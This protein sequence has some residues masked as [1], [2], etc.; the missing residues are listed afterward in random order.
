MLQMAPSF[1]GAFARLILIIKLAMKAI[2][3]RKTKKGGVKKSWDF[4]SGINSREG[5]ALLWTT[6]I[7]SVVTLAVVFDSRGSQEQIIISCEDGKAIVFQPS[8]EGTAINVVKAANQSSW[9]SFSDLFSSEAYLDVYQTN[10]VQDERMTALIFPPLYEIAF[11][12]SCQDINCDFRDE[13]VIETDNLTNLSV[14][15]NL[16]TFPQPLPAE[17]ANQSLTFARLDQVGRRQVALFVISE[18]NEERGLA[19][20]IENNSYKPLITNETEAQIKTKYGKG[21]GKMAVGGDDDNFILLYIGYE[22]HAFHY[23]EGNLENI[24]RFFGLRVADNGFYPYI[25]KQGRGNDSVWYVLSLNKEKT[26]LIKLWQNKSPYIVGGYDLSDEISKALASYSVSGII[27]SQKRGEVGFVINEGRDVF[28]DYRL[29]LFKDKG[30][31]NS[32]DRVAISKNIKNNEAL[33]I[34]AWIDNLG[35][36]LA[37]PQPGYE[38]QFPQASLKVY[39]SNEANSFVA[40]NPGQAVEFMSAGKELYW[41]LEFQASTDTEYSPWLDHVM[42]LEY[43]LNH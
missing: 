6:L 24:S 16:S 43:I 29:W 4:L 1:L 26:K 19:Y 2:F 23:R 12:K 11:E 42:G 38:T 20:F 34:K 36:S 7:I 32:S 17:V 33:V 40:V 18:G 31:D 35:V 28:E 21:G 15:P 14:L 3:R 9:H 10:M 27:S 30:F 22:G 41:K 39:L 25:I 37:G 13:E 5:L 8:Q